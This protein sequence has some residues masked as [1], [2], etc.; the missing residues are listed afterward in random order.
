MGKS[1]G[2]AGPSVEDSTIQAIGLVAETEIQ[3][4]SGLRRKKVISHMYD[5]ELGGVSALKSPERPQVLSSCCF[6]LIHMAQNNSPLCP[7]SS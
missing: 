1:V 6:A 7:H 5:A 2:R 3:N 4:N